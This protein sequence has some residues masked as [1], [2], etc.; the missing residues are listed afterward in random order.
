MDYE[1]FIQKNG[2]IIERNQIAIEFNAFFKYAGPKLAIKIPKSL[3][4]FQVFIKID[5][6]ISSFYFPLMNQKKPF[7]P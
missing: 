6:E 1:K 2:A 7:F 5:K 3:R 4:P